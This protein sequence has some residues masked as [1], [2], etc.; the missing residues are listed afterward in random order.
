VLWLPAI[1]IRNFG[2]SARDVGF[3]LGMAFIVGGIPGPILGGYVADVLAK[4][5]PKWRAWLPAIS[6]AMCI[7]IYYVCIIMTTSLVPFI[8]AFSI[9]Y[10]VFLF[11][12]PATIALMQLSVEPSQRA[13]ALA[14]AMLVNNLVG[15]AIG[16][17]LVGSLSD[18][19][20]PAYGRMSLNYA[21][22]SICVLFGVPGI[23]CYLW[24]SSAI[25]RGRSVP[26]KKANS[27]SKDLC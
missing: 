5:N 23:L 2:L 16:A 20:A 24:T 15:Q 19:L 12:T 17:F 7:P 9:G 1:M 6:A 21:V 25:A 27:R 26:L 3:Y 8:T 14:I 11:A 22:V 13:S 18:T 10:F 4:R